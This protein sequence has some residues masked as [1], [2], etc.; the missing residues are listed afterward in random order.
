MRAVLRFKQ[1]FFAAIVL[2][3][4]SLVAMPGQSEAKTIN[5]KVRGAAAGPVEGGKQLIVFEAVFQNVSQYEYI[6]RLNWV[7]VTVHGYFDG[8]EESYTR[9][10]NVDW[11]FSPALEPG[12]RK[13]LRIKFRRMVQP[14]RGSFPYD[15]VEIQVRNINFK[16]TS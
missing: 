8:R 9:K 5:C 1:V 2:A 3:C 15:D 4:L 11:D 16:R 13:S 6:S 14:H 12:Q 10:V 7:E